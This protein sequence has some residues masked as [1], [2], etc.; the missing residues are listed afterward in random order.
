MQLCEAKT[1]FRQYNRLSNRF[2]NRLNNRLDVR[3]YESNRL[4]SYNQL[5]SRL[6]ACI[7]NTPGCQTALRTGLTTGCIV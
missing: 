5:N 4:N 2:D 3:L 7:R 6:N 1:P